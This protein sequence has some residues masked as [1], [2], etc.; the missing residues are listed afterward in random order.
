MEK[1]CIFCH[2]VLIECFIRTR[3]D[4]PTS[5]LESVGFL[6]DDL[7]VTCDGIEGL[8]VNGLIIDRAGRSH[9]I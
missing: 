3:E 8:D 1:I 7:S 6:D 5:P 2:R 9:C 4:D